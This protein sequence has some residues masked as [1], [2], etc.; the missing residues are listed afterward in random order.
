MMRQLSVTCVSG[1][2][3]VKEKKESLQRTGNTNLNKKERIKIHYFFKI[4]GRNMNISIPMTIYI[5]I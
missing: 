1:Y 2:F 4:L 3:R 5:Y